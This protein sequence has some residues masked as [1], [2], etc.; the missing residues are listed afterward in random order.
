MNWPFPPSW[1]SLWFRISA[2][3]P[4]AA[5]AIAVIG[6]LELGTW[7]PLEQIAYNLLFQARGAT[8]WNDRIVLITVDEASVQEFG[9]YPWSRDRYTQLLRVLES[10]QPAVVGF[11]ILFAEPTAADHDFAEAIAFNS[12]V[13]L[14]VGADGRGQQ[15]G[16]VPALAQVSAWGHVDKR[17]DSD[18]VSR[19]VLLYSKDFPTLGVAMLRLYNDSLENTIRANDAPVLPQ[20]IPLPQPAPGQ[21]EKRLWLNWP[22]PVSEITQYSFADVLK[23]TVPTTAFRD[24]IVLVG[25]TLTGY[26]PLLTPFDREPPAHGIHLHAA[27]LD[28][29]LE[30]SDLHR[31]PSS[32]LLAGLLLGGPSISFILSHRSLQQQLAIWLGLSIAWL[33]LSVGLFHAN[34][35]IPLAAPLALLL[36]SGGTVILHEQLHTNAL[37]TARSEFLATMSHEIRTPMNAV[38]GM[39]GLLLDTQLSAEQRNFT[40]IIRSSG[41]SLLTLINDI[42]D[43]SKIES[44]NLELEQTPFSL[45]TCIEES[46]DLLAS[47]ADEKNLELACL[48]DPQVPDWVV[49]DVTRLRQILVN[50]ISNA[51]KFT[52]TGEVV[53]SVF[54]QG[55]NSV[56]A[57]SALRY[58]LQFA[59]RDTGIGISPEGMR[60]LFKPFSQVDA[61]TTRKY[62]GTGLGLIISKR[63]S[64]LMGGK[65]W[66]VSRSETGEVCRAGEVPKQAIAPVL[67]LSLAP[68]E[69]KDGLIGDGVSRQSQGSTFYFTAIVQLASTLP[70]PAS[71]GWLAG[72]RL[73]I[74]DDNVTNREILTL[75]TQA[76][77]MQPRATPSGLEAL[78]W[79]RQGDS[80]DIGILDMQMPEMDGIALAKEIRKQP[81]LQ[82]LPLILLTS[83]SKHELNNRDVSTEF[84]AL[85]TKPIKQTQLRQVLVDSLK[86]PQP[87]SLPN[88]VAAS[89]LDARMAERLPLRILLAEDNRV[90]QQV[91]LHLLKRMGYRVDLAGNGLEVLQAL[92]R[93]P[94]DVILMDVRMPEMDGLEATRQIR[95]IW[96][97]SPYIIAMTASAMER[98]RQACREA[99]MND[100]VSKPFRVEELIQALSHC[101]PQNL[102]SVLPSPSIDV[103]AI[104]Q[105][106]LEVL[107]D[108]QQVAGDAGDAFVVEVIDSYLQHTPPLIE[109]LRETVMAEDWK[110]LHRTAHSL[111]SSSAMVGAIAFSNLCRDLETSTN[112]EA[113][114]HRVQVG[115]LVQDTVTA[116][117]HVET[118]LKQKQHIFQAKI[119]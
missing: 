114:I 60:R 59:V 113:P 102:H 106:N 80:F 42:L 14:A 33:L 67:A 111:K 51:V 8:P 28:N 69:A 30:H 10:S 36:L 1:K 55:V 7:N 112:P 49:G 29:L 16:F 3:L 88:A 86:K 31:L 56:S 25:V 44:G 41:E 92:H 107:Q 89:R 13:V 4:G 46:L 18:G 22:G 27:V 68:H 115:A 64:E 57:T 75:Q 84:S 6:L 94:Y 78:Q 100:F 26:D 40:E 81:D 79:L 70:Q 24:K 105:I 19:E 73:L 104:A 108:L 66:V 72:R 95:Q 117:E 109:T 62:G 65:M 83:I 63:L 15:V 119:S 34:Y 47:K 21:L 52:P 58:E 12:S 97:T 91:A 82:R 37:L 17:L 71:E 9:R 96:Q 90:N 87:E 93:Q 118:A 98:D 20:P 54:T 23:G 76:W 50:L 43:F 5:A 45:R 38:I 53:V 61:S 85:L 32:W 2:L 116:Y 39:T 103:T 74:V 35:W 110:T 11:D 77:G 48:I 101:P 99:G